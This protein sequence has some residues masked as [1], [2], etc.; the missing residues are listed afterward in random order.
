MVVHSGNLETERLEAGRYRI[1][2]HY[3]KN[4]RGKEGREWGRKSDKEEKKSAFRKR[5]LSKS[6]F[7]AENEGSL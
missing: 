2:R 1:Q 3:L 6:H 7:V 5:R 4:K